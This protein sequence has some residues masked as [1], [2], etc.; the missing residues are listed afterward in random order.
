MDPAWMSFY[1]KDH[2]YSRL[3]PLHLLFFDIFVS[4]KTYAIA[5][6]SDSKMVFREISVHEK[7]RKILK[8]L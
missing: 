4:F 2:N 7:D 8:V 3:N 1:I 6:T 5:L